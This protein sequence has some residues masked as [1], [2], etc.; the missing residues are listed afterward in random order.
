MPSATPTINSTSVKPALGFLRFV[1]LNTILRYERC[2]HPIAGHSRRNPGEGHCHLAEGVAVGFG[3][4][5]RSDRNGAGVRNFPVCRVFND[6]VRGGKVSL[7]KF[8]PV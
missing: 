1:C 3:Y 2:G 5:R 8:R 7:P 4:G 6:E